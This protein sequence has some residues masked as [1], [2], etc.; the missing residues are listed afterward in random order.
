MERWSE[1]RKERRKEGWVGSRE[2]G[3]KEER[4]KGN[5]FSV[6]SNNNR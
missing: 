5:T 6:F 2:G 1:G 3:R 4:E